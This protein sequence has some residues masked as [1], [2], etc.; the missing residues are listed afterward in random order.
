MYKI[1]YVWVG[2]GLLT[3]SCQ[4]QTETGALTGAGLGAL[5]GGVASQS[6]GGAVIG[7]AAGSIG[8]ALFGHAL[9]DEQKDLLKERY[10]L[11]YQKVRDQQPLAV[12]DII[13][14]T[15]ALLNP[16][17][18]IDILETHGKTFTFDAHVERQLQ[19]AGVAPSLIN[20][21][22][23]SLERESKEEV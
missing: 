20:Y 12:E 19:D 9:E 2:L 15:R 11:T 22:R 4:S 13:S 16:Y 3:Q 5:I 8:G 1:I 14:M 7:A 10:P 23:R 21:F 17:Q 18:I 6:V